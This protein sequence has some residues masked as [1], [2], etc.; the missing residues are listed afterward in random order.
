MSCFYGTAIMP[1]WFDFRIVFVNGSYEIT[2]S[3]Q[4]D[5]L[6]WQVQSL[7]EQ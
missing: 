3:Q 1:G 6:K 7:H 4:I 2:V 5:N